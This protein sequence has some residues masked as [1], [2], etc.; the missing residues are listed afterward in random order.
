MEGDL[1]SRRKG[2][3]D[4]LCEV[5]TPRLVVGGRETGTCELGACTT[6]LR[7]AVLLPTVTEEK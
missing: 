4:M 5:G 7:A 2:D 1:E 3:T 6:V